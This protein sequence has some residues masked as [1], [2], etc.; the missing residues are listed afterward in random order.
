MRRRDCLARNMIC[1]RLI[2]DSM[3]KCIRVMNGSMIKKKRF[4]KDRM[5]MC[6]R[7]IKGS[8]RKLKRFNKDSIRK[9]I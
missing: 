5:K 3:R 1:I 2:T 4:I 6:I 9:C 8:M 7:F